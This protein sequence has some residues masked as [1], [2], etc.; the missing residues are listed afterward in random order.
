V[1]LLG[2]AKMYHQWG[3]RGPH[4]DGERREILELARKACALYPNYR[5][6]R[7]L[8]AEALQV[9]GRPEEAL[10]TIEGAIRLRMRTGE[11]DSTDLAVRGVILYLQGKLEEAERVLLEALERYPGHGVLLNE[12]AIAYERQ[13]RN[14]EAAR[15]FRALIDGGDGSA[16]RYGHLA[17]VLNRL[18][19]HE[20]A[21]E[22]AEEALRRL[23]KNTSAYEDLAFAL[24]KLGRSE[25]GLEAA[26]VGIRELPGREHLH[27]VKGRILGDLGKLEEAAKEYCQ[28]L[29]LR[30]DD[31]ESHEALGGLLRKRPDLASSPEVQAVG[32]AIEQR[33]SAGSCE[34]FLLE[35]LSL[36]R[37]HGKEGS[38]GGAPVPGGK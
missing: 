29:D 6:A 20:E 27:L 17:V 32:E 19:R 28:E 7:N 2:W 38:G 16:N 22:A 1:I 10:S 12:L 15:E 3:R 13:G 26:E 25:E 36:I 24:W 35:T 14:E 37:E 11:E 8:L 34:A 23:P 31:L 30:L 33:R 21:A 5:H 9:N 18:G 4:W